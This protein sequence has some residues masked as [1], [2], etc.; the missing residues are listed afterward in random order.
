MITI[1]SQRYLDDDIIA[2]KIEM[3]DFGVSVSPVFEHD[4]MLLRVIM[5]GHHSLAAAKQAG[6]EPEFA[7]L[8]VQDSD[9]IQL[10]HDGKIEDFLLAT[11]I[12][13]DYYDIAD[14]VSIW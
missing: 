5:D 4:G 11:Y 7:E 10:I 8:D 14:G 1:S 3:E 12:D 9:N 2:E 6:V 13:S